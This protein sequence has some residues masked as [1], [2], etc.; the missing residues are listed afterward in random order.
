MHSE[1]QVMMVEK[2]NSLRCCVWLSGAMARL[3][4]HEIL[5]RNLVRLSLL[6]I[7]PGI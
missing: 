6:M 3:V 1:L 2:E 5:N 4:H 7:P